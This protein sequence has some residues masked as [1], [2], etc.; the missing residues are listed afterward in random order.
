MDEALTPTH[1]ICGRRLLTLPSEFDTSA[2]II[3]S[4]EQESTMNSLTRRAKYLSSLL[5]HYWKKWRIDY[6]TNI[7]ELHR[8]SSKTQRGIMDLITEGNIVVVQDDL[9][10]TLWSLGKVE[11]LIKG[12][13]KQVRGAVVR[14]KLRGKK[15][16]LLKRPINKLYPI[17]V[18]AASTNKSQTREH[19]AAAI[20]GETR[21]RLL[22]LAVSNKL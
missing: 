11:S 5:D 22:D 6:L 3:N 21:R 17:E 19:R 15:E 2:R 16:L 14:T 4:E 10:R 13:D 9:P 1:L 12:K 8:S 20:D 7:R 18:R